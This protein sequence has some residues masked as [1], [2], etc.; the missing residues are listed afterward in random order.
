MLTTESTKKG[1]ESTESY[2]NFF[3]CFCV[4]VATVFGS[5]KGRKDVFRAET[6]RAQSWVREGTRRQ[7]W[8]E[9]GGL[10]FVIFVSMVFRTFVS[11][12]VENFMLTTESTKKGTESTESYISFSGDSFLVRAETVEFSLRA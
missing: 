7:D 5:R 3:W 12:V 1:T 11:F 9:P 2:I 8:R 10:F 6:Q 4:L